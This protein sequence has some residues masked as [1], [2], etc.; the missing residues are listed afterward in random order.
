[1]ALAVLAGAGLCLAALA[2]AGVASLAALEGAGVASLAGLAA[3]GE[4]LAAGLCLAAAGVAVATAAVGGGDALAAGLAGAGLGCLGLAADA[5][6]AGLAAG[7]EAGGAGDGQN[8]LASACRLECSGLTGVG[9]ARRAGAQ[10]L[11]GRRGGHRRGCRR[12]GRL[13][14]GAAVLLAL[15]LLALLLA[16][17]G[18]TRGVV[19]LALPLLLLL[20]LAVLVVLVSVSGRRSRRGRCRLDLKGRKQLQGWVAGQR[21][22]TRASEANALPPLAATICASAAAC[23]VVAPLA[24]ARTRLNSPASWPCCWRRYVASSVFTSSL[25]CLAA[26]VFSS[27]R[28]AG[29]GSSWVLSALRGL[30]YVRGAV[31][32]PC[33]PWGRHRRPTGTASAWRPRRAQAPQS[34]GL[35]RRVAA[36]G[37][38]KLGRRCAD[39]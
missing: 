16:G 21:V 13:L 28:R 36:G 26:V 38:G 9:P 34:T 37:G 24:R 3:G 6:A 7:G 27:C 32:H 29:A 20:M 35:R 15:L 10:R 33:P 31:L 2:G 4:G 12:R 17:G 19:V 23:P 25:A 14:L 18:G 22:G 8:G 5:A 1:M 30:S 39:A 11:L